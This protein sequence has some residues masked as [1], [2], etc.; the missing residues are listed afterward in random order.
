VDRWY[1]TDL[2]TPRA[3]SAQALLERWQAVPGRREVPASIHASP[4]EALTSAVAAAE[5]ADRIL[6]FGSF[7]TVG[8]VLAQGIPRLAA[9]HLG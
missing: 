2:P 6:V 9:K 7:Y 3:A 1:F 8:G 5:P 4:M